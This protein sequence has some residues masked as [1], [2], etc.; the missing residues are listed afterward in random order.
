LLAD[1][2]QVISQLSVFAGF[3]RKSA[4]GSGHRWNCVIVGAKCSSSLE[5]HYDSM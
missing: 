5:Q 2:G 3:D 4:T 1:E